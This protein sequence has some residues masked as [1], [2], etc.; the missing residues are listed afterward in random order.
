MDP[1][2]VAASASDAAE[3]GVQLAQDLYRLASE[4]PTVECQIG[5]IA[6]AFVDL[7][8]TLADLASALPLTSSSVSI[9]P[10]CIERL[11]SLMDRIHGVQKAFLQGLNED[12][13]TTSK[14]SSNSKKHPANKKSTN[15]L[16]RLKTLFPGSGAAERFTEM[17]WMR[18]TLALL[19]AVF[20]LAVAQAQVD[21]SRLVPFLEQ[22][23]ARRVS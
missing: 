1:P 5:R 10:S 7:N 11:G 4:Y 14:G 18:N 21:P 13:S 8:L 15:K 6:Q 20:R 9:S 3:L 12:A 17:E 2:L 16:G 22:Q 19:A 23:I